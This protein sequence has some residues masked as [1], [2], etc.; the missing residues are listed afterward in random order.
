MPDNT[1]R[2]TLRD[3]INYEPE[4]YLSSDEMALIKSTF[5][6]NPKLIAVLRK[7]FLPTMSDP[8]L[9]IEEISNDVLLTGVDW[10]GMPTEHIKPILLGRM[11][12][13]KFVAGGLIKLKMLS[14][15]SEPNPYAE[16][17]RRK[18]DSAK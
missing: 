15:A 14:N 18:K 11:E 6:D 17:L 5:K 10:Q 13:I 4:M 2:A 12:A 9:P 16:A 1:Q 7:V 8:S 3:V